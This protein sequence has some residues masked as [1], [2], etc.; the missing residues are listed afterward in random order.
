MFESLSIYRSTFYLFH[1]IEL[2]LKAFLRS[3]NSEVEFGHDIAERYKKCCDLGLSIGPDDSTNI[4]NV[5]NLMGSANQDGALR[6]F[7]RESIVRPEL[8]WARE[9]VERLLNGITPHVRALD[10]ATATTIVKFD[11][12]V[13]KPVKNE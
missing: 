5:I 13:T 10:C 7:S 8:L 4:N 3:Y 9:A 6:Y 2:A 1:A 12:T 11:L